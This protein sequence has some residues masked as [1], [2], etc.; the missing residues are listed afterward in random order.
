MFEFTCR[1]CGKIDTLKYKAFWYRKNKG[2]GKCQKC[3]KKHCG[4]FIKGVPSWNKGLKVSG[5]SGKKQS[6][7][8]REII[9]RRNIEDNPAKKS[10]VKEKMRK[11]KLGLYNELSNAWLGGRTP[12]RKL[13]SQ[14]PEYKDWRKKVFERDDYTC[15]EC[16]KRGGDMEPHHIKEWCNYPELRLS[17]ENGLTLCPVCHRKTDNFGNKSIKL[18]SQHAI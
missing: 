10:W 1:E 8:Q 5:M 7:K 18:K 6:E 3:S 9:R 13:L 11:A 17:V 14:R 2:T 4:T 15:Q 16:G 12:E